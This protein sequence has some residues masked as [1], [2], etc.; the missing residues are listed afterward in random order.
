MAADPYPVSHPPGAAAAA[1]PRAQ[2]GLDFDALR[3]E[4]IDA[5][6]GLCSTLWT[7]YNLHDPGVTVLEQLVYGLTDLAYRTEFD[8]ADYLTGPDGDIA[9]DDLALHPP[10]EAFHGQA[11]TVS[12]YRRLLYSAI[13]S[14]GEVWVRTLGN[15]L[16]AIE[17]TVP[18]EIQT[19]AGR[20][21]VERRIRTH[22]AA[23]RNLCEDLRTVTVLAA[24]DW[25][26]DGE[27]EVGGERAPAE[28]LAEIVFAC[29]EHLAGGM[30]VHRLQEMVA[31]GMPPETV[32]EGPRSLKG[33]I[34]AGPDPLQARTVTVSELVGVLGRIEGVRR[35]RNLV[36]CDRAGK[37]FEEIA[38]DT[39]S[40]RYPC[41]RFP[42]PAARGQLR[43]RAEHSAR[44]GLPHAG[45][46]AQSGAQNGAQDSNGAAPAHGPAFLEDARQALGKLRF[47]RRALLALPS[48]RAAF[49]LPV[50]RRRELSAYWSVQNDFPAVYGIGAYG[51]PQSAG[52]ERITQAQQL[53][54]FLFPFEQLMANFLDNLQAL[55]TLF[56]VRDE[57]NATYFERQLTNAEIP[58]IEA[59]RMVPEDGRGKALREA[60]DYCER[61][62][63][64]YDYLLALHGDAF[65][66]EA[67]RRFNHYHVRDTERWLLDAK[68]RL[69]R[70]V[71]A[72]SAWRG[73]AGNYRAGPRSPHA[74]STLERRVAILLGLGPAVGPSLQ[75]PQARRGGA[76]DDA[77]RAHIG[78]QVQ[79]R[80]AD[81]KTVPAVPDPDGTHTAPPVPAAAAFTPDLQRAGVSPAGYAL[82]PDPQG[83]HVALYCGSGKSWARIGDY[84]DADAATR[85][86]HACMDALAAASEIDER[87]RIVEHILLWP[88][89]VIP[90]EHDFYGSR[91][92]IVLPNWTARCADHDFRLFVQET[93]HRN[94]PAHIHPTFVW[95]SPP[96]M[97]E[98]DRLWRAWR[99]AFHK[100][101]RQ[102]AAPADQAGQCNVDATARALREF[103]LAAEGGR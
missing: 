48:A 72:L 55:P 17:V 77:G 35:V 65:P 44:Y 20:A 38:C 31:R 52:T 7:D 41:L 96:R 57:G 71:S 61:K 12:D 78:A 33:Y 90:L 37:R 83:R 26:L 30:R 32:Y 21:D 62:G 19:A 59:L 58:G 6:Q 54:G 43:L 28:I 49:P 94:C 14:V 75:A 13:P 16:L 86:A 69:L 9:W 34:E 5:L 70:H 24:D 23:N 79:A 89:D 27:I 36:F 99:V 56:S 46:G 76:R 60:D 25:Y 29:R 40:G 66:Q 85:A 103:L 45:T 88:T 1:L 63:R 18:P 3:A 84:E 74:F 91:M 50:G 100:L 101:R 82:A 4:G 93:V 97:E 73:R 11:L 102:P 42:D 39:R 67:L 51:L 15:G 92:S 2:V 8:V 80:G 53:K 47:N 98:F 95:L 68:A 64:I 10:Q 81:W 22:Y 87:L